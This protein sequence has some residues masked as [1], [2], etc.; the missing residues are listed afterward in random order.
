MN[1]LSRVG[2]RKA[3][4][5]S[6]GE[7]TSLHED[8][9]N[10]RRTDPVTLALN[11]AI[12]AGE[13]IDEAVLVRFHQVAGIANDVAA[14]ICWNKW[15]RTQHLTRQLGFTPVSKRDGWAALDQD[16]WLAGFTGAPVRTDDQDFRFGD[17]FADR[18]RAAIHLA[19]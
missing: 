1:V 19:W 17:R 8:F 4:D 11:L 10:L 18:V 13:E 5:R 12:G 7:L 6:L 2:R 9:F 3:D 16:S 14:L 15:V